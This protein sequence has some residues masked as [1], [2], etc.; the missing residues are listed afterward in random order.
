MQ[1]LEPEADDDSTDSITGIALVR[2][3][4]G[5]R[6]SGN[7]ASISNPIERVVGIGLPSYTL[8]AEIID[9]SIQDISTKQGSN[10]GEVTMAISGAK[11]TPD[12]EITLTAD[13][14]T[15][16]NAS[17]V[18]WQDSSEMWATFDLLGFETGV[19]DVRIEDDGEIALADDIF[20]VTDGAV[21]QL[22]TQLIGPPALRA[23]ESGVITINYANTGETDIVAPLLTLSVE[24]ANFVLP[25]QTDT[26]NTSIQF[27]GIDDEGPA[28]I[29]E[30]GESGSFSFR[31]TPTFALN[32]DGDVNFF[33]SQAT[34]EQ[35][36]DWAEIK[37]TA[38]PLNTS[39]QAWDLIWD[40]F[41][42]EVGN[43]AADYQALLAENANQL[44]EGDNRTN[45]ISDLLAF[46][47]Q[48]ATY[49]QV[50][51]LLTSAVDAVSPVNGVDL[52]FGRNY[53][54]SLDLHSV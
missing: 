20:T 34:A 54:Q 51:E 21:G 17:Q 24:N 9:F 8:E 53:Y 4:G 13:N 29:I 47:F 18:W 44:S 32:E 30:P 6:G 35:T 37:E 42:S 38:Q 41:V 16:R 3:S 22:E 10:K 5:R 36:I 11:F 15:I 28:G 2:S 45:D 26:E 40:N 52:S 50:G 12:G 27:L 39:D 23:G 33:L 31:F 1:I 14:G 25:N 49:S 46:E 48:Q 43:T 19:Y 7:S